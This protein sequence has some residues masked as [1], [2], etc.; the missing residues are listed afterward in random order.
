[1]LTITLDESDCFAAWV[2]A[3]DAGFSSPDGS[4]PK[5]EFKC[6]SFPFSF[7][8]R[9]WICAVFL[10]AHLF[11]LNNIWVF[12]KS[13]FKK[14]V[15]SLIWKWKILFIL[16]VLGI[17]IFL[18]IYGLALTIKHAAHSLPLNHVGSLLG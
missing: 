14:P 5:R 3:K 13:F 10:C 8:K 15:Y 18:T 7:Q 9:R 1:M 17:L 16:N 2:S 12:K 6:P 11:F 4:D